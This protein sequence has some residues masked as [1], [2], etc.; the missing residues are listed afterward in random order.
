VPACLCPASNARIRPC[1]P[2]AARVRTSAVPRPRAAAG[3]R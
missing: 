2:L 1:F 3:Q